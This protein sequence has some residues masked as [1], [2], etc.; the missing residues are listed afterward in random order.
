MQRKTTNKHFQIETKQCFRIIEVPFSTL[1]VS[2]LLI[3][4]LI[5]V[6]HCFA[7]KNYQ[8][9][10]GHYKFKA[11]LSHFM[12]GGDDKDYSSYSKGGGGVR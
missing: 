8:I 1:S 12:R 3:I 7:T 5:I 9:W 4:L 6:K 2:S 11:V 10:I